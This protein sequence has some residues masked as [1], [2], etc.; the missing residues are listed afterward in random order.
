MIDLLSIRARILRAS[1]SA[2][3]QAVCDSDRS[4]SKVVIPMA[5]NAPI[6]RGVWV[7]AGGKP[8]N[9]ARQAIRK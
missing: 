1:Y 3:G 7:C 4:V 2:K 9:T 5:A 8:L 6:L